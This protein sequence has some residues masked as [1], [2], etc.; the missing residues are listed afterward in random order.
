MLINDPN[1]GLYGRRKMIGWLYGPH[2]ED[3]FKTTKVKGKYPTGE[4]DYETGLWV[5]GYFRT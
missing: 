4:Y 1:L 2:L 3:Q 5:I